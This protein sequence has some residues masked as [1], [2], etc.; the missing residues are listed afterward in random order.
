MATSTGFFQQSSFFHC[1]D[2]INAWRNNRL[3]CSL[4]IS[5]GFT[6]KAQMWHTILKTLQTMIQKACSPSNEKHFLWISVLK[7][8]RAG[9]SV[10]CCVL[11]S[12]HV[13]AWRMCVCCVCQPSVRLSVCYV[14][15]MC[16]L[17]CMSLSACSLLNSVSV[18]C[19]IL[20]QDTTART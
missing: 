12:V 9:V 17:L 13:G 10:V 19:N 14:S 2:S 6:F 15:V 1:P 20:P 5:I 4:S 18:L 16:V 7:T 3:A 8:S 11:C